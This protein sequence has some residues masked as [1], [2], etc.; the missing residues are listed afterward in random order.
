MC[1]NHLKI[2]ASQK[3]SSPL[4]LFYLK[5]FDGFVILGGRIEPIA[6]LVFHL[7]IKMWENL[8][9]KQYQKWQTAVKT[10]KIHQ[11][12]STET[13]NKRQIFFPWFLGENTTHCFKPPSSF[14][15]REWQLQKLSKKGWGGGVGDNFLKNHQSKRGGE[16]ENAKFVRVMGFSHFNLL[17]I[18]SHS[19]WYCF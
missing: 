2:L 8:Y 18:S 14:E 1:A 3:L 7:A 9:K 13:H 4:G 15:R 5:S 11:N 6:C 19:N 12:V 10:F 17:T 16:R